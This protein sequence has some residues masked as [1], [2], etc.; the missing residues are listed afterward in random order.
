MFA[1]SPSDGFGQISDEVVSV[2]QVANK[3]ASSIRAKTE[4]DAAAM[5]AEAELIHSENEDLRACA[6]ADAVSMLFDAESYASETRENA[7]TYASTTK[8]KSDRERKAA[9][10]EARSI[11]SQ[12]KEDGQRRVKAMLEATQEKVDQLAAVEIRVRVQS[13]AI[14]VQRLADQA[15]P[16]AGIV[17]I[18]GRPQGESENETDEIPASHTVWTD[19]SSAMNEGDSSSSKGTPVDDES[20][21][22]VS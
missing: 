18:R 9:L 16:G 3:T 20:S 19:A 8:T 5:L 12:A 7:D 2:L 10:D 11:R 22:S 17:D 14:D 6:K 13:S 21:T 4:T 15:K 1:S